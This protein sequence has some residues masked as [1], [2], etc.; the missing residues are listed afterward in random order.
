MKKND[1]VTENNQTASQSPA[2]S[3]RK[4]SKQT[5][6]RKA[7]KTA[8]AGGAVVTAGSVP[9]KWV[10]PVVEAV[11]L[12]AHAQTSTAE[13]SSD[14]EDET[15]SCNNIIYEGQIPVVAETCGTSAT[16]SISL[17]PAPDRT[18]NAFLG[19]APYTGAGTYN[20]DGSFGPIL[21]TSGSANFVIEGNIASDCSQ[22]TGRTIAD[23]STACSSA[24]NDGTFTL[25]PV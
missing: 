9:A 19:G 22:I 25:T 21:L 23:E 4:Q 16:V 7:L 24:P 5:S 14:A 1:Q 3:Q 15:L 6:R 17:R 20:T 11:V 10:A 12:P 2:P 18:L 13:S 8:L